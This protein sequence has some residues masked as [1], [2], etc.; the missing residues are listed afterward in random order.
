MILVVAALLA[1]SGGF[2][3]RFGPSGSLPTRPAIVALANDSTEGTGVVTAGT[4]TRTCWAVPVDRPISDPFRP[5]ECRWCSGN[6]GIEFAAEPGDEIRSVAS[7]T[8]WFHGM[9]GGTGYLT[10][11]VEGNVVSTLVTVGGVEVSHRRERGSVVRAGDQIGVAT[12][13]V[14][15]GV[16]VNGEYVD[17]ALW[18]NAGVGRARLI[19]VGE[20]P[21]PARIRPSCWSANP[22]ENTSARR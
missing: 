9:V 14:H 21:R 11:L 19:P 17:P 20:F 13:K 7:G 12:G 2:V 22:G 6:R 5:P 3:A 15:L 8:V 4:Q 16:R 18:L 10:L 1:I